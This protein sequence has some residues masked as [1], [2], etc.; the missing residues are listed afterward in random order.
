MLGTS[1]L[2]G[3]EKRRQTLSARGKVSFAL[4]ARNSTLLEQSISGQP[5]VKYPFLFAWF[6]QSCRGAT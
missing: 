3:S 6:K 4:L 1:K 2:F 5:Y